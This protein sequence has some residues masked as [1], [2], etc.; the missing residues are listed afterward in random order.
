[1]RDRLGERN[2]NPERVLEAGAE[3]SAM[4]QGYDLVLSDRD[5]ERSPPTLELEP[6]PPLFPCSPTSSSA[7]SSS[8]SN[9]HPQC[10]LPACASDSTGCDDF[11]P[12]PSQA[13]LSSS[14]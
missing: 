14:G 13:D 11:D 9:G 1:M 6:S 2:V 12:R 4:L 8:S 7:S 10:P 5:N 3:M